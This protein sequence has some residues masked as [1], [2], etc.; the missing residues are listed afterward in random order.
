M[1]APASYR[2][3]FSSPRG[4][5]ADDQEKREGLTSLIDASYDMR[6]PAPI[7]YSEIFQGNQILSILVNKHTAHVGDRG[8]VASL[9][10]ITLNVNLRK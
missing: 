10:V 7:F 1:L 2:S 8:A 4:N 6:F 3:G 5:G 9:I